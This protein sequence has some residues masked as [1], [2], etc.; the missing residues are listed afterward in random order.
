MRRRP[1][2]EEV[3]ERAG[4]NRLVRRP[5]AG[6]EAPLEADLDHDPRGDE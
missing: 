3:T 1:D 4:G 2:E 6:I 5:V